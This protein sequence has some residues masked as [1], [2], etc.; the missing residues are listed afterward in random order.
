M[1]DCNSWGEVSKTI[2]SD[3][4]D[5]K[6]LEDCTEI[7]EEST[8]QGEDCHGG[9]NDWFKE[10]ALPLG[11]LF[12]VQE[13]EDESLKGILEDLNINFGENGNCLKKKRKD[14]SVVNNVGDDVVINEC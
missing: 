8:A 6:V 12:D 10:E 1:R 7:V 2:F 13:R 5:D 14:V 4:E 11:I 9:Y 3:S